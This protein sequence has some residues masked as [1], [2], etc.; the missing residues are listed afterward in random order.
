MSITGLIVW[1]Q[2]RK[3]RV[4]AKAARR[5]LAFTEAAGE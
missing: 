5:R 3:P 4:A 2:R 1:W